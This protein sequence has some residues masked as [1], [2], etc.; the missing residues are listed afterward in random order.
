MTSALY[1]KEEL[2]ANVV[3]FGGAIIGKLLLFDIVDA[4]IKAEYKPTE[5]NKNLL[6][7]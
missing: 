6:Q 7:N 3:S 2:N 4:F 1:S 5:E